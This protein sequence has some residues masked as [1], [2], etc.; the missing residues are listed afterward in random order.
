MNWTSGS[1]ARHARGRSWKEDE[2]RQK[3]HFAR[4][5]ALL[6]QGKPR[7]QPSPSPPPA[8]V[9]DDVG[10]CSS[11]S[12]SS[13][14]F[15]TRKARLLERPDWAGLGNRSTKEKQVSVSERRSLSPTG[16]DRRRLAR[17]AALASDRT[18]VMAQP[19][20]SRAFD[21]PAVLDAEDVAFPPL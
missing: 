21:R 8:V 18:T 1:L 6:A 19:R 13:C 4:A 20:P 9:A 17:L 14:S 16:S 12:S 11:S 3:E 15:Q 5:R 10:E 2:A 7:T